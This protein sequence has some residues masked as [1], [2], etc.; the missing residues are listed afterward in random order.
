[1]SKTKKLAAAA[2]AG[3]FS[4]GMMTAQA[5]FAGDHEK[6]GCAAKEGEKMEKHQCKGMKTHG[7]KNEKHKEKHAC[8]GMNSCK[9]MGGD[10]KNA[11]KSKGSCRTDDN[12]TEAHQ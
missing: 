1:M 6:S 7:D 12:N 8:K 4:V 3:L 11:C 2:L 5:S 10:G 9:S